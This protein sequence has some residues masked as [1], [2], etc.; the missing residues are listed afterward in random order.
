MLALLILSI[1]GTITSATNAN[2]TDSFSGR[3]AR[4]N[5][6]YSKSYEDFCLTSERNYDI[7]Y[8]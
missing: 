1:L 7:V 8:T 4:T 2:R 5:W 6:Y 3:R